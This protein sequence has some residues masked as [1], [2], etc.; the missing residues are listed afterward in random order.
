M[1]LARYQFVEIGDSLNRERELERNE[2]AGSTRWITLPDSCHHDTIVRLTILV[3]SLSYFQ[4]RPHYRLSYLSMLYIKINK[5]RSR[6]CAAALT[7]ADLTQAPNVRFHV[8][9]CLYAVARNRDNQFHRHW[10]PFYTGISSSINFKKERMY[11][12]SN[13]HLL[14]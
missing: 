14:I 4:P 6:E 1:K 12:A 13:L 2:T 3:H 9:Y 10:T 5:D 8:N 7:C 11:A